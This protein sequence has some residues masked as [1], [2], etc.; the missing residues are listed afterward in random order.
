VA[1]LADGNPFLPERLEAERQALGDAFDPAGTLWHSPA[2][3][4]PAPNVVK[5][6]ERVAALM[7][8][9]RAR[10]ADGV[11]HR[12]YDLA[13]YEGLVGYGLYERHQTALYALA[14][15]PEAAGGRVTAYTAFRRDRAHYLE[16]GGLRRP[17]VR[18][19]PN[20]FALGYQV[21][22]RGQRAPG[23]RRA[24]TTRFLFSPHA[25]GSV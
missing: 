21:R 14:R 4:E 20:L 13:L 17:A 25:A 19:A 8:A 6:A 11:P 3:P 7:D 16:V 10:L 23:P 1:Q 18:E 22:R 15:D 9:C 5:L 12:G 2:E 24:M